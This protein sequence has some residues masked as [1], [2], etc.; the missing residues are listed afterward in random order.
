MWCADLAN[1]GGDDDDFGIS[2]VNGKTRVL[3]WAITVRRY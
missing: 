3:N 1:C 2:L